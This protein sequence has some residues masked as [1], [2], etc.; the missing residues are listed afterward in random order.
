M[1]NVT[2]KTNKLIIIKT[3]HPQCIEKYR[4]HVKKHHDIV[5][6]HSFANKQNK[7]MQN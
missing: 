3:Q 5:I 4:K 2:T 1:K 7:R 6:L